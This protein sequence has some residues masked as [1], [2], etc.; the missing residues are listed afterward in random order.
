M[1]IKLSKIKYLISQSIGEKEAHRE[2]LHKVS[3]SVSSYIQTMWL[4]V[5][6][7]PP[8]HNENNRL[9]VDTQ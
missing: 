4:S 5:S 7:F 3:M 9:I 2:F 6:L 1:L 8:V